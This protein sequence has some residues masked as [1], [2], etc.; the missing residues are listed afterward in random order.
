LDALVVTA[1]RRL[2]RLADTPVTTELIT[3]R[4]IE[5]AR[6]SDLS[7]LLTQRLGIQLEGG[8]PAGEGVMLQGLGSERVLILLDGQPVV[9]RISGT[10]DISRLPTSMVERVE[11]VKGSQS[12]LYGS[13][14]MGGVVNVITRTASAQR[15][16]LA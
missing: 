9:G 4:D 5:E 11:V 1:S 7:T 6:V 2:E 12:S 15:W 13:D 14:A 10:I 3:R 8:H 16:N